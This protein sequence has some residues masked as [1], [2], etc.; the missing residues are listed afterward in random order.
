MEPKP[1]FD[2]VNA[3]LQHYVPIN[4]KID[5]NQNE[6]ADFMFSLVKDSRKYRQFLRNPEQTLLKDKINIANMDVN[7]FKTVAELIMN[8][9]KAGDLGRAAT[10]I[11][12]KETSEGVQF[13]F[14]RSSSATARYETQSTTSR[15]SQESASTSEWQATD[16]NFAGTSI[17]TRPDD[18][19]K[20]ELNL[21]FFP[22]QPLVTPAL[23]DKIRQQ[24]NS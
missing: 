1:P 23:V 20:H 3:V 21:I 13:N 12:Q 9:I 2:R 22:G 19:L 18:L 14:D 24:F 16:K 4:Q 8:K 15:G 7:H 17:L 6:L 10:T 5:I 11:S